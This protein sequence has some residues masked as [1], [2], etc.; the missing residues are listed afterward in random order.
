VVQLAWPDPFF[1]ACQRFQFHQLIIPA[2]NIETGHV[3]WSGSRPGIELHEHV[4]LLIGPGEGTRLTAPEE[5]LQGG[6]YV[7][8]RDAQVFSAVPVE[9]HAQLRLVHAQVAVHI[10]QPWYLS[11]PRQQSV[12]SLR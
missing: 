5:H 11:G 9:A 3:T 2:S 1:H 10:H 12:V 4:V 6:C 7:P 8:H